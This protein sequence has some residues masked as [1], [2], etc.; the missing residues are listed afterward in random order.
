MPRKTITATVTAAVTALALA[1]GLTG[2]AQPHDSPTKRVAA[3]APASHTPVQGG[4]VLVPRY[5][6]RTA[7]ATCP[8]GTEPSGGGGVSNTHG[9]FITGSA[10]DGNTWA[11]SFANYNP[12]T[13]VAAAYVICSTLPHVRVTSEKVFLPSTPPRT[14]SARAVCP[15]QHVTSGGGYRTDQPDMAVMSF[16]PGTSTWFVRGVNQASSSGAMAAFVLCSTAP[17][18]VHTGD[19]VL[20]GPGGYGWARAMCPAGRVAS[21]G[22]GRGA[23][24]GD[25][26][27]T[28]LNSSRPTPDGRGW[29]VHG[30]NTSDDLTRGLVAQVVCTPQ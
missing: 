10:A 26:F 15:E 24:S 25:N 4:D 14:N 17:H 3:K 28:M 12:Q 22:G 18:N 20:L 13:H 29:E 9:M 23:Y 2:A 21:G 6:S 1:G 8:A 11:T 30:H 27:Y 5:E 16:T 19:D 7:T